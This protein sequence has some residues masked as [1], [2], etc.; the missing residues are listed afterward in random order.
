[1]KK[2]IFTLSLF[3]IIILPSNSQVFWQD[4][5]GGTT[6]EMGGGTRASSVGNS[7]DGTCC[8]LDKFV[9][10]NLFG[11]GTCCGCNETFLNLSGTWAWG[12]EDLDGTAP[13]SNAEQTLTWTGINISGRTNLEFIGL[14]GIRD[15]TSW[16]GTD[17][18]KIQYRIDGGTL[19]DGICFVPNPT[20]LNDLGLDADCDGII[21]VEDQN[22]LTKTL[23]EYSFSIPLTG[24]SLELIF[25]ANANGGGEEFVVDNFR[26]NEGVN[27]PVELTSFTATLSDKNIQLEWQ[28]A[29]EVNNE[30]FEVETSQN[31]R[32]FKKIGEVEGKGTTV[33]QQDYLFEINNPKNGISY[34][35]LKQI[36]FDGQFEY[37][38]VISVN[39]KGE[40][41]EIGEFYPNPS[42]S[43][44]VNLD[45]SSKTDEE[46]TVSV[47]DITGKLVVMEI[48]EISNGNNNLSFN[49]SDLNTG[50]YIVKIGD[51]RN[52]NHQK[53]IIQR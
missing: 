22:L 2:A 5:F 41:G 53:L 15:I 20:V 49:F 28:T 32:E 1:M 33:E 7:T 13:C 21:D 42:K 18:L 11:T 38:K 50:I 23:A 10:S 39:F 25:T 12:G 34:Y 14:F 27:V 43:G 37:S 51:K 17:Q 45:Y 16:E 9:R 35:R 4:D 47:F 30:K 46:I 24:A 48:Q 6:P 29:S 44:L 40:N 31:G 52:Q 36:D 3:F 26:L 8:T 19:T